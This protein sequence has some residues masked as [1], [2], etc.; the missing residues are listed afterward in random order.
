MK[1]LPKLEIA[2]PET[3]VVLL[4]AQFF[5]KIELLTKLLSAEQYIVPPYAIAL[6]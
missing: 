1:L 2:P 5:L 3:P 4:L 6:L